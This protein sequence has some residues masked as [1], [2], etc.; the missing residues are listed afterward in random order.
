MSLSSMEQQQQ[1][2][3]EQ[4]TGVR[5]LAMDCLKEPKTG[6]REGAGRKRTTLRVIELNP[7]LP[8]LSFRLDSLKVEEHEV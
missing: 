7:S 4:A 2:M 3:R 1:A 8:V 5:D 6:C